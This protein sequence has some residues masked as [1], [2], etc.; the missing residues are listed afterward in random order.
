[1]FRMVPGHYCHRKLRDAPGGAYAQE[2][3][4]AKSLF[5]AYAKETVS[6]SLFYANGLVLRYT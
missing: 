3:V 2:T 1:M 6:K 5:Y 4:Y